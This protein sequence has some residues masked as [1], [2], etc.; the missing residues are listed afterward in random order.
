MS[1]AARPA[2]TPTRFV[3]AT[4]GPLAYVEWSAE[5]ASGTPAVLVPG[6]TGSKEDFSLVGELLADER[7]VVAIDLP[8]QHESAGSTDP[9]DYSVE[10]LAGDVLRV[11]DLLGETVHLVGHSLGGLVCRA[12]VIRHPELIRSFTLM[13]SGPAELSGVRRDRLVALEPLLDVGGLE[14]VYAAIA[15]VGAA[16]PRRVPVPPEVEAFLAKRFMS[17]SEAGLRG[18][19]LALKG[20]PDRVEELRATEVPTLVVHGAGDDAWIPAIQADMAQRLGAAYVVLP[21]ALHSPAAET[22]DAT[23]AALLDF[24]RSV[25]R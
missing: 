14:M 3:D 13:S 22:P 16:D 1:L 2:A 20:E 15:A 7:R 21:D 23:A 9:A 18:M 17:S 5:D 11:I 10:S 25:E 19:G 12:A 8:G 4:H 6:Y 24:W